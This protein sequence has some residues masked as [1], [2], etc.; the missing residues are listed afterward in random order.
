M[1]LKK[2]CDECINF[3]K[4]EKLRNF[5]GVR[6]FVACQGCQTNTINMPGGGTM[7]WKYAG[8]YEQQ[9]QDKVSSKMDEWI[10]ENVCNLFSSSKPSCQRRL[11]ST[12][13]STEEDLVCTSTTTTTT[14]TST[15]TLDG[16]KGVDDD[17]TMTTTPDVSSDSAMT[18]VGFVVLALVISSA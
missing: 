14:A 16:D 12:A 15:T 3:S 7:N 10:E 11:R 13:N 5:P 2:C 4:S 17:V 8:Q 1:L 18:S 9:R 6:A